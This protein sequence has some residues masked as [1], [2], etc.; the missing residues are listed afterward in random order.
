MEN[1]VFEQELIAVAHEKHA[2]DI[3]VRV[4]GNNAEVLMRVHGDLMAVALWDGEKTLAFTR[5][6]QLLAVKENGEATLSDRADLS[7]GADILVSGSNVHLRIRSHAVLP[8]GKDIIFR[9]LHLP[10]KPLGAED[11]AYESR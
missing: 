5:W 2:S 8:E 4:R 6:L 10:P 11:A 3:Q 7:I 1:Y 9:V